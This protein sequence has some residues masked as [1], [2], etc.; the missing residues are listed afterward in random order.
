[1]HN[2]TPIEKYTQQLDLFTYADKSFHIAFSIALL[3]EELT[4]EPY[5]VFVNISSSIGWIC[6]LSSCTVDGV[7]QKAIPQGSQKTSEGDAFFS[8][9]PLYALP[10]L[11]RGSILEL[12]G[13]LQAIS[14][15]ALLEQNAKLERMVLR[16]SQRLKEGKR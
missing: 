14:T 3:P 2:Y 13:T 12:K 10:N 9:A 6:Q 1:M 16:M 7:P 8:N 11:A 4:Q 5:T 15:Q